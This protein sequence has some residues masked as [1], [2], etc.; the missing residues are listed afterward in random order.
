MFTNVAFFIET[1]GIVVLV[2]WASRGRRFSPVASKINRT[3]KDADNCN[4]Q[5]QNQIW[6]GGQASENT[7]LIAEGNLF[8]EYAQDKKKSEND[9]HE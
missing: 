7:D 1:S 2:C 3:F 4:P 8:P 9:F 5:A 6:N